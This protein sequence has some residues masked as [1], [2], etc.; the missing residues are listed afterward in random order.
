MNAMAMTSI[1]LLLSFLYSAQCIADEWLNGISCPVSAT[2]GEPFTVTWSGGSSDPVTVTLMTISS[3]DLN[4]VGV[5][6]GKLA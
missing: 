4:A 6:T 3:L 1:L 2:I 5:L